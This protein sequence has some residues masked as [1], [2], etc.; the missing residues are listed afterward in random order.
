MARSMSE[1]PPQADLRVS[2]TQVSE[3]P[4][5]RPEANREAC[6]QIRANFKS[7]LCS[8]KVRLCYELD[9]QRPGRNQSVDV[10][11]LAQTLDG[12]GQRLDRS[13]GGECCGWRSGSR[14]A[15][16]VPVL[17]A[18][19]GCGGC[20]MGTV[21]NAPPSP[22]GFRQRRNLRG[23]VTGVSGKTEPPKAFCLRERGAP[24]SSPIYGAALA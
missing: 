1:R 9:C 6:E 10:S 12:H 24:Q 17:V 18:G 2:S 16:A 3:V 19:R 5:M 15:L 8:P 7:R 4:P 11:Y 20:V 13:R 14:I 21:R 23:P 22:R